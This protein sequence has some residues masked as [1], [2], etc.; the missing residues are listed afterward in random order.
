MLIFIEALWYSYAINSTDLEA[1]RFLLN[2]VPPNLISDIRDEQ[3]KSRKYEASGHVF[4]QRLPAIVGHTYLLR[5][6]NFRDADNLVALQI[7]RKNED[8]SLTILW[9]PIKTFD[10]PQIK[11]SDDDPLRKSGK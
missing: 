9:K 1:S 5:P 7:V 10:I 2:Y 6:I 8:Q 4:V 3:R 11:N